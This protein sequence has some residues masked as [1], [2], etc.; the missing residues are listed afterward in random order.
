[1]YV[2]DRGAAAREIARVLRPGGRL[3]G[4]VW[5]RAERGTLCYSSRPLAARAR[6]SGARRRPGALG[7]R[8]R[9][10]DEDV[11]VAVER[12]RFKFGIQL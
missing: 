4:A 12:A 6:V 7:A 3:V 11:A 10:S 9:I 1:M 5:A 2:I 8:P